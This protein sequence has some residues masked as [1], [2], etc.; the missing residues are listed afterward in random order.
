MPVYV[1]IHLIYSWQF[2]AIFSLFVTVCVERGGAGKEEPD[3][4]LHTSETFPLCSFSRDEERKKV[5]N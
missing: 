3:Y 5:G 2:Q 4:C 1:D